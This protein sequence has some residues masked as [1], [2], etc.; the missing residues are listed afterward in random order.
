MRPPPPSSLLVTRLQPILSSLETV[1]NITK[2]CVA[3]RNYLMAYK[4]FEETNSYCPNGFIDHDI[5]R[6]G[7]WREI[8]KDNSGLIPLPRNCSKNIAKY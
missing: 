2:T 4:K 5:Q 7:E 3:L 8:V 1:E 6:N